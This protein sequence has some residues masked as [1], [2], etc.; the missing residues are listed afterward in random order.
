MEHWMINGSR[1]ENIMGTRDFFF[2]EKWDEKIVPEKKNVYDGLKRMK[3]KLKNWLIDS[4]DWLIDQNA[5]KVN[6]F[7]F[8][9][10]KSQESNVF[11]AREEKKWIRIS[12]CYSQNMYL[13]MIRIWKFEINSNR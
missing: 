3:K 8:T 1:A 6:F 9:H 13:I 10:T 7:W 12:W 4:I 2:V 5:K 11:I